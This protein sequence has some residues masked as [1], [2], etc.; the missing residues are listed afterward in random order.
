MPLLEGFPTVRVV[1]V[2]VPTTAAWHSVPE[3][4]SFS[5]RCVVE[6]PTRHAP[7]QDMF[8]HTK[9][10]NVRSWTD[11]LGLWFRLF[12][13]CVLVCLYQKKARRNPVMISSREFP[14]LGFGFL[15]CEFAQPTPGKV[16]KN[17]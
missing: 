12:V 13:R 8:D 1:N 7:K 9:P 5:T 4:S 16:Q 2:L 14:K 6:G 10:W 15:E 17:K 11:P 3:E